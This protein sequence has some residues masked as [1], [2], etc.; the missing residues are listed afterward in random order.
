MKTKIIGALLLPFILAGC[1]GDD[2]IFDEVEAQVRFVL[3]VDTLGVDDSF[4][5]EVRYTNQ[6]GEVEEPALTWISSDTSLL[7]VD[8][9]GLATGIAKGD[10]YLVCEVEISDRPTVRDT[11][12][13]VI[14]GETGMQNLATE[15][16]GTLR[17]TSS[18]VLEG[19]FKLKEEGS[20]LVLELESD[21][22]ASSS[23]PGLYVY[24][25]NNPN[26]TNG[27]YEIGKVRTFSGSHSFDI[28]GVN[29]NDF[30]YVLYFC[31]PFGV[32]VGDGK[33]E[34]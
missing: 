3:S 16:T 20:G 6:I 27:A 26:S 17:T 2:I 15:R 19:A 5:F 32:K 24:L 25:T 29:L 21:Y 28:S 11:A 9:T 18:Y 22:K 13:V 1:I 8:D 34:N 7:T 4:Q 23:L 14:A 10:A 31:K 30:D 12:F 33:F